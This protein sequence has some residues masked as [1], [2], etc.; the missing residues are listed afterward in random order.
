MWKTLILVL[1]FLS[2]AAFGCKDDSKKGD[3]DSKDDEN[4]DSDKDTEGDTNTDDDNDTST[5]DS[6]NGPKDSSTAGQPNFAECADIPWSIEPSPINM[7]VILDRS[8]SMELYSIGDKT[9]AE[10]VQKALTSIVEQNT[11]AKTINFALNVFPSAQECTAEYGDEEAEERDISCHPASRFIDEDSPFDDPVVPFA[12]QITEET[13]LSIN[14]TLETMGQCGGTPICKS[15]EWA[16]IY[17]D[18]LSLD[19]P[20]YVLLATDGA[21]N[22]NTIGDPRTCQSSIEPDI[23]VPFSEMCLDDQCT[24]N[25]T[26]KLASS[27]FKTFVIGVGDEVQQ[28]ANLLDAVA[29]WGGGYPGGEGLYTFPKPQDADNW[30]YPAQNATELNSAL[31]NIVNSTLSCEFEIP[32]EEVPSKNPDDGKPVN[33]ACSQVRIKGEIEG[34]VIDLIYDHNCEEPEIEDVQHYGWHWADDELMGKPYSEIEK[35]EDT[36]NCNKIKLCPKACENLKTVNGQRQWDSVSAG[37]GCQSVIII[38]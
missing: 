33:K 8:K 17:L 18:G 26:M 12:P 9:Y 6:V 31:E 21:P 22:C 28:F 30:F 19:L 7:L 10:V 16:R 37:F 35:E 24:V 4:G 15:L 3:S 25:E 13:Y 38:K 34:D 11:N 27:G 32:W 2:L 29:F 14:E 23:D 36:S 1:I 20:T 5:S